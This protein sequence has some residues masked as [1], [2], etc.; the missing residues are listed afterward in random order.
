VTRRVVL[1][2]HTE[3]DLDEQAMFIARDNPAEA[4]AFLD[5]VEQAFVRL[6]N[7]PNIGSAR[8]FRNTR[9]EGIRIWPVPEY[10]NR[11]IFCRVTDDA[12]QIL[13]ILHAAQDYTRFFRDEDT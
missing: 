12:I 1:E 3:D 10:P 6:V 4:L 8:A 7:Y 13:R 11:L 2:R 9:L 5:A